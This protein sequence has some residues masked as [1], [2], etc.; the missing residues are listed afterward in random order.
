MDIIHHCEAADFVRQA[1]PM[2]MLREAENNLIIGKATALAAKPPEAANLLISISDNGSLVGAAM[3]TPPHHLVMTNLADSAVDA[4]A[5]WLHDRGISPPGISAPVPSARRLAM[6]W[7]ALSG[8]EAQLR[9]SLRVFLIDHVIPPARQASGSFHV[10]MNDDS[11]ILQDWCEA[12]GHSI[13]E[14][15][16]QARMLAAERLRQQAFFVWKD[17]AAV[18][19]AGVAGPTPNGIRINSVYTPPEHRNRGYASACVAALSQRML[20][21]GRRF[22]FLYT[23]LANPTSNGIYAR[24][25]YRR[26]CDW[27]DF[28]LEAGGRH[29]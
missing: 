18:S 13:G 14:P 19:M 16:P 12:F 2:L 27:S 6:T 24:I 28:V 7:K 22:C 1:V 3:M 10:A 29:L 4:L 9:R 15:S 25:G 21:T 11:S 5:H 8:V 20:D 17:P 23:D 26:V